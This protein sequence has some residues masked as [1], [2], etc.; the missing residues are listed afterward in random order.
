MNK[1]KIAII[2]GGTA[3]WI[4]ASILSKGLNLQQYD[5]TLI[6]SPDIPTVGVGEATVPP[7]I[8]LIKF[9]ELDEDDLLKSISATFKYGIHFEN[10]SNIG[11]NYMHAFGFLGTKYKHKNNEIFFPE[12]W[13]KC[14]NKL[15]L[16][17]LTQFSPAGV[18]AYNGKFTK[19]KA[20][21]E[22]SN[23]AHYFPL[24]EL[25][26]AYQFDASLLAKY[27][28]DYSIKRG[29]NFIAD[30]VKKVE[31]H[32]DNSGIKSVLLKDKN[33]SISAD[34]FVDCT[35]T[36][37][38]L[39]RQALGT[40]FEN[41]KEYLPCDTAITVQTKSQEAP[42]P[43]T[44]SIAMSSG[45]RWQIPLQTRNGNGYVYASDF[46]N[47]QQAIDEFESALNGTEKINDIR[48]IPFETGCVE[49]PWNK[50]CISIGLSAGFLEPLE[51]TSISLIHTF[52]VDFMNALRFGKDMHHEAKVFNKNF[53]NTALSIRDFLI[54]HYTVTERK[55][56]EFWRHCQNIKKPKK[57]QTHLKEFEKTGYINLNPQE[58]FPYESW[59]QILI[60]QNYF[61]SYQQLEDPSI[62]LASANTFFV[63]VFQA[64]HSEVN[65]LP[66][67]K[68]YIARYL[69]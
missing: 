57:L 45:W 1:K 37:S 54:L 53:I 4:T 56:S 68:D 25:S 17:P 67:H 36:K 11:D 62:D 50:N 52:A 5:I 23:P 15:A 30:T 26:Y 24:S 32:S 61:K 8:Q 43:Y 21:P 31:L 69:S 13:M 19:T 34:Y 51:S 20:I 41:W 58:I 27:L 18:A 47:E 44:K 55:D 7:I 49:T 28:K 40:K 10:W 46:I 48:S 59:V 2:G 6:E 3:G 42:L 63:N 64:I 9:L 14:R 33:S 60:G 29:I 12:M 39:N 38:I 22:N 65:K 66:H 16:P 35:G